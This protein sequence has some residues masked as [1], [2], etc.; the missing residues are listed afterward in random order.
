[1]RASAPLGVLAVLAAPAPAWALGLGDIELHSA[2]NQPFRAD[3][4]LSATASELENL[5]IALADRATFEAA[6]LDR[7]AFMS[8]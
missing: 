7:P 4:Q 5:R 2:L 6:G 1:M 8:R 3:I